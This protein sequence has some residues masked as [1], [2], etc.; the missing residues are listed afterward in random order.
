M[1]NQ[2][3]QNF[4]NHTR[5]VPV[6]VV[7]NIILMV[8]LVGRII[9]LR[10]G[11]SYRSVMDVLVIAAVMMLIVFNRTSTLTVQNRV[12]RDEMRHRL[13]T[14]LPADLQA[15][16]SEFSLD[17]VVSLRFAGDAELPGLARKVLDEKINDRK[18]IKMMIKDW[19]EDTLRA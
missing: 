3:P 16:I 5:K 10:Q 1:A 11:V 17:Q 13:A 15:R 4:S 2:E 6:F 18:A 7:G 12:I 14:L 19:Q 9:H 8:A